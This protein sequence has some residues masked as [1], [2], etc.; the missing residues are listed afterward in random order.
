MRERGVRSCYNIRLAAGKLKLPF[1]PGHGTAPSFGPRGRSNGPITSFCFLF[2]RLLHW[3][4]H[5]QRGRP[6]PHHFSHPPDRTDLHRIFWGIGHR[7]LC[8]GDDNPRNGSSSLL[9]SIH[10]R[11]FGSGDGTPRKNRAPPPF[12]FHHRGPARPL[13]D[14]GGKNHT[15]RPAPRQGNLSPGGP[16][17]PH[18]HF[19]LF[20][21]V[22]RSR[23]VHL[24]VGSVAGR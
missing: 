8:G 22:N 18:H 11:T 6:D 12:S 20:V 21:P 7:P 16:G 24:P 2:S 23:Q 19:H 17:P 5:C 10:G 9:R 14:I 13:P 15:H 1:H 4:R 3:W